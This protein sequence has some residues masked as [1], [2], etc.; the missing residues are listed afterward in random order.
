LENNDYEAIA[1]DLKVVAPTASKA[2]LEEYLSTIGVTRHASRVTI[3]L[4]GTGTPLREFLWS[5]DMADACIYLMTLPS[6]AASS[7]L[8][9]NE[10]AGGGPRPGGGPLPSAVASHPLLNKEGAGGGQGAGGGL[11][12]GTGLELSISDLAHLIKR[13]VGFTGDIAFD[14]SKPDG[15]PRKLTDVSRLHALGWKHKIEL[16]EGI[17]LLYQWYLKTNV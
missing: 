6:A 3:S 13:V 11:N 8:L 9:N 12:L 4:W 10:G 17:A 7:P 2:G 16:R 15:T 1:K 5:D 14:P